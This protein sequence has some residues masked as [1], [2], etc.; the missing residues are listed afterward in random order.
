MKMY[1]AKTQYVCKEDQK[2]D[3]E[4]IWIIKYNQLKKEM[5]KVK[6]EKRKVTKTVEEMTKKL[7]ISKKK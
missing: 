6:E 2:I 1:P 4:K 7:E 3:Y 5:E